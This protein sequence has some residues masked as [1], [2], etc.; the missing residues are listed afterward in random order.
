[1]QMLTLTLGEHDASRLVL[2]DV[3]DGVYAA[4]E[5]HCASYYDRKWRAQ[6]VI[7]TLVHDSLLS[8]SLD[9]ASGYEYKVSLSK[10]RAAFLGRAV[11]SGIEHYSSCAERDGSQ[12]R[13]TS[14]D[15]TIVATLSGLSDVIEASKK[16]RSTSSRGNRLC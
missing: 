13:V 15:A 6:S 2:E 10:S 3:Q 8:S 14:V 7:N 1:M 5:G 4:S 9:A 11:S 12:P 16:L